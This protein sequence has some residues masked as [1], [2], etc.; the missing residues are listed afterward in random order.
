[1]ARRSGLG[2]GLGSLIPAETAGE[3][4]S[5]TAGAYREIPLVAITPNR[6]QPRAHFDE[7]SLV[8]LAAS[9]REV[10]VIQPVLLRSTGDDT[11]ELIA[12]ER[13]WRAAK[14]AGLTTIPALIREADELGSVE[15]ALVEN[16]HRE[17]LSPLEEAGAYQELI[18]DF[19]LTH[20][21][22]AARVGKSRV[23]ITNT[24]RLFQ[25][26]PGIQKLIA[27]RR[28]S[29]G[30]ARALLGTPDRSFQEALAKRI[31]EEGLSVRAVEEAV[32][33]RQGTSDPEGGGDAAPK[34]RLRAPGLLELEELLSE[35]LETR[36]KVDMGARRGKVVIEFATL[37]DLERI[38]RRMSV[39]LTAGAPSSD[40]QS[41][42]EA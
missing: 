19:G 31:V 2:K 11:Y 18:E 32:R 29:A 34:Q 8:T 5:T 22:L 21:E 42:D 30:H 38:Y 26:P 16:L 40:P 15:Q 4:A 17:D 6:H 37:E 3:G 13:R 1:V 36:V 7:E 41:D 10:G 9:V 24:L 39:G 27:E 33:T 28:L 12:G 23:A 14:R 35:R 20:D 25:L